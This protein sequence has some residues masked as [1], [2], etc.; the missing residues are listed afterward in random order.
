M[1]P[2][3]EIFEVLPNGVPQRMTVVTGLELAKSK[4]DKLACQTNNE[5]FAKDAKTRQIVAHMNVPPMK[6]RSIKRIFIISYH[7]QAGLQRAAL[8]RP[9]GYDVVSIVDNQA[10]KVV[11]SSGEPDDLFIVGRAAP[12]ETRREI[13]AWLKAKYPRGKILALNPPHQKIPGADYNVKQ[14]G[15]VCADARNAMRTGRTKRGW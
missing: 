7:E 1:H 6:R 11:L 13:V 10:A 8:L 14:K 15:F 4:L 12:E 2:V 5:C 9:H 3:Y